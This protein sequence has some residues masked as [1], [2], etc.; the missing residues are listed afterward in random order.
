MLSTIKSIPEIPELP[1]E[2]IEAVNYENLAV[3]IGAG[4]SKVIGCLGWNELANKLVER[5]CDERLITQEEW[6]ILT[7]WTDPKKT[8]D[9]CYH[10]L[11]EKMFLEE[12][13]KSL[14]EGIGIEEDKD[15]YKYIIKL[16]GLFLTTNADTHFDKFFE[17]NRIFLCFRTFL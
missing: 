6:C 2:I 3:F 10:T 14:K 9:V 15:I 5:C 16:R 7:K 12:L 8:I 17:S 4:V 11:G 1:D 13:N